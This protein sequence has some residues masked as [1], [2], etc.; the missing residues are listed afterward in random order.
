MFLFVS[1]FINELLKTVNKQFF[2]YVNLVGRR[3][4]HA[5]PV[6]NRTVKVPEKVNVVVFVEISDLLEIFDNLIIARNSEEKI[7]YSILYGEL[8]GG[9]YIETKKVTPDPST[10]AQPRVKLIFLLIC[11]LQ[12]G[13]LFQSWQL[14]HIH[15]Q[16]LPIAT[17]QN[18]DMWIQKNHRVMYGR[19]EPRFSQKEHCS[20]SMTCLK[21]SLFLHVFDWLTIYQ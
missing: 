20:K 16:V 21:F 14:A 3:T 12:Q 9:Q 10:D 5:T 1:L 17:R 6:Y 4:R 11:R 8:V 18:R 7:E 15:G 13:W 19:V 2:Q